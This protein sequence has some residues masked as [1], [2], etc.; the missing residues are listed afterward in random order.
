MTFNSPFMRRYM[1]NK[2]AVAGMV[3]L[4]LV[5]FIAIFGPWIATNDPWGMVQQPFLRPWTEPGFAMG[6][7]TLGRDIFSGV[8]HGDRKS[9]V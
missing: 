3:V 9:V 4:L 8:I 2:G 7:D 1:R 6:T 5:A